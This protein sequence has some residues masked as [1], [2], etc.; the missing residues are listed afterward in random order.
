MS[1][2]QENK[3]RSP[4]TGSKLGVQALLQGIA[5]RVVGICAI[6]KAQYSEEPSAQDQSNS[7]E[8]KR[9]PACCGPVSGDVRLQ[10]PSS[11]VLTFQQNFF[12]IGYTYGTE[13][14]L[15]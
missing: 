14:H 6:C 9:W 12:D 8:E 3:K 2:A 1:Q 5:D 7:P 4:Q 13:A 10:E 11:L 15:A